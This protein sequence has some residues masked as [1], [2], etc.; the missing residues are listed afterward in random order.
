MIALA[1]DASTGVL[2][3]ALS[4][5]G[6]WAQASSSSGLTHAERIIPM[7]EA[8]L[9]SSGVSPGDLDIV[10][11][12]SGPGSFTGLRIALSTAKGICAGSGAALVLAPTLEYM[13]S[14][15]SSAGLV[16][17][18]IDAKKGRAY[19]ALYRAGKR[20]GEILDLSST[21][22]AGRLYAEENVVFTGPDADLMEEAA[23]ERPSWSVD[24]WHGR[25]RPEALVALGLRLYAERG[26]DGPGA[27]PLYVRNE[28]ADIGITRSEALR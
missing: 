24:P 5:E 13:A 28:E 25:P 11:C 6:G 26:P 1:L 10:I 3:C 19:A 14:G 23:A 27:G 9:S 12:A 21:D 15:C 20:E 4:W 8:L 22:L 18:V 2:S 16:I 17:P 7:A